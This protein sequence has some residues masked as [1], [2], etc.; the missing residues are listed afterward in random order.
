VRR[1]GKSTRKANLFDRKG[2]I[3]EQSFGVGKPLAGDPLVGRLAKVGLKL[4]FEARRAYSALL[5]KLLDCNGA[6]QVI[7]NHLTDALNVVGGV[8]E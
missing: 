7:L 1:P 5:G 4:T 8:A 3:Q 6:Q 2:A